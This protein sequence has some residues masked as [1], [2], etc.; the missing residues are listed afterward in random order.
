MTDPER[1]TLR[2]LPPRYLALALPLLSVMPLVRYLQQLFPVPVAHGR[3]VQFVNLKINKG[4][5]G[6]RNTKLKRFDRSPL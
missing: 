3:G 1:A 6:Q 4:A 5:F 2:R